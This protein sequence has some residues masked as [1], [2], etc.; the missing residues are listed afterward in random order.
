MS[1][2]NRRDLLRGAAA[3]GVQSLLARKALALGIGGASVPQDAAAGFVAVAPRERLLL[4]FDWKFVLGNA[5]DPSRDLGFDADQAGLS[6]TVG[7]DFATE[8]F[9]DSRWR[10]LNLPHD[11][12]VELPFV[13][14][15]ALQ[16]HGYKPLGRKYPETSVGWYRR[17]FDI[18]AGDFG[19]RIVLEFDGAF[20][21]ALVFLNG[22]LIGRHD[23]GYTPFRFDIS[24]FVNY[25]GRN[26]L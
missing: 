1:E 21:S 2:I 15:D 26:I 25:G 20:R 11:W 10:S 7:Y 24:D 19:R 12:A 13:H 16:S 5:C 23:S 3:V 4:D 18:P 9:D 14:D 22:S 8:K 6:K 17:G